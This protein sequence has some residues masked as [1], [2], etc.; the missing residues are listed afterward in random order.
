MTPLYPYQAAAVAGIAAAEK[1]MLNAFDPGLGKT[2]VALAILAKK[3]FRRVLVFCP[4]SV[5]LVWEA[6][7]KKWWR[8][9]PPVTIVRA[10]LL[11]PDGE[12]VFLLSYGLISE[13]SGRVAQRLLNTHPFEATIV[14]ECHY[15]KNPRANRSKRIFDLIPRLGWVHPMSGTP[16]P[17]NASEIWGLLWHLRPDTIVSPVNGK[18]MYEAEFVS[19][20]CTVEQFKVN[21]GRHWVTRV[22]GNKNNDE[23]RRRIAPMVLRARKKD[24]LPDLPPLDFVVL[25]I[26]AEVPVGLRNSEIFDRYDDDDLLA[27]LESGAAKSEVQQLGLAKIPAVVEWIS[28]LLESDRKRRL[29]VWAMHHRVIDAYVGL[30]AEYGVVKFD[31]SD[32]LEQRRDVIDR[33]MSGRARVFVGQIQAGGTGLTLV[34]ETARCSDV[35]F[36]ESSFSWTDNVQAACRIHR[37]GQ[38]DG[39][40]ARYASVAG[41]LDDRIQEILARKSRD[42][43]EVFG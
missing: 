18:P 34:S 22:T 40:L 5:V 21:G 10:G 8:D 11:V 19:R 9:A 16:A 29:V 42:W 27:Q 25:P 43:V 4:H 36:A 14:D 6:E 2:R 23:L 38:Q 35:I 33:F 37:I 32:S 15:L 30:L 39:V 41:T 1:P 13:A 3:G 28:D 12:G 20:Y 31:G 7:V 24:V 26:N 17:N